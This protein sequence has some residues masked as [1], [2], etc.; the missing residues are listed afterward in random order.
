MIKCKIGKIQAQGPSVKAFCFSSPVSC[1]AFVPGEAFTSLLLL[2]GLGGQGSFC[3]SP[4]YRNVQRWQGWL[5]Y[6]KVVSRVTWVSTTNSVL[7]ELVILLFPCAPFL[8]S[9]AGHSQRS[10]PLYFP[11]LMASRLA[12]QLCLRS[13]D[14][15]PPVSNTPVSLWPLLH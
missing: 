3:V 13:A 12:C 2:T 9:P 14:S 8:F 7:N 10:A 11:R 6:F 4:S 5:F 1:L 15:S